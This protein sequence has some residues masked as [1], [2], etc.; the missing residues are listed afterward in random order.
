MTFWHWGL[1]S[2]C[3][4]CCAIKQEHSCVY[5]LAHSE[6]NSLLRLC[7]CAY[8]INTCG[9]YYL[10][11]IKI[12]HVIMTST[13]KSQS[14]HARKKKNR[15]TIQRCV[16]PLGPRSFKMDWGE[17]DQSK[18]EIFMVSCPNQVSLIGRVSPIR[19][20]AH[21]LGRVGSTLNPHKWEKCS[22][23]S[24]NQY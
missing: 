5:M 4:L 20:S 11:S 13:N 21:S 19:K 1:N 6:K 3:V 15:N 17:S 22:W 12:R 14:Y 23:R 24:F 9:L 7:S 10:W 8:N 18:S 2:S 16:C